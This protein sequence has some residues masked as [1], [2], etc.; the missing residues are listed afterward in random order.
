MTEI[1]HLDYKSNL[2]SAQTVLGFT[3]GINISHVS[4]QHST[5]I[6]FVLLHNMLFLIILKIIVVVLIQVICQIYILTVIN[7]ACMFVLKH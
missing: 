4:T 3:V 6:I 5:T 1:V 2:Y 7:F